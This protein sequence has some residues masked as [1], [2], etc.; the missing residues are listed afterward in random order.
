MT[1]AKTTATSALTHTIETLFDAGDV[2]ELRTFKDGA[3]FSGYYDDHDELI[4]QAAKRDELGHDVYITFNKLPKE[5]AY[6]RYNRIDR[7]KGREPTTSDKDIQRRTFIFID[8]DCER[9]SGISSTNEEKHKSREKVL[10]IRATLTKLGWPEPI[11]CDSGNGYHLLYPIDLAADQAG[12]DLVSSVLEALDFKFSDGAVKVDTTTKNAAR[13]TK[14]YGTTAKKGDNLPERPHRESKI[15]KVPDE[16][17]ATTQA[18]LEQVASMKPEE[19]RRPYQVY[20]GGTDHGRPLDLDEWTTRHNVPVKRK[21]PWQR[22]YRYI[23]EECLWNGHTDNSAYIVQFPSGGIYAGCQHDSCQTGENRWRELRKHYEPGAYEQ[24]YQAK[25]SNSANSANSANDDSDSHE[26]PEPW[27]QPAAFHSIQLPEFPRGV[28]PGWVEAQAEGVAEATQTHRDL[29]GML[30][31]GVGAAASA[32]VVDVEVWDGWKEQTNFYSAVGMRSGSRK[33]TVFQQMTAPIEEYEAQLVE[34][35]AEEIAEQRTKYKIYEERLKKAQL[36]AAKANGDDFDTLTADALT[37]AKDLLSIKV[38]AAPRLLVDDASPER[39]ATMLADQGGR[40]A[41]MSPEGGVFDMMAGR[42]SQGIPNLDVYLKGHAGDALRVD[43]V[44]RPADHVRKPALT[45]SLAVQP[46]VFQGLASRPGFRGRGLIGRVSYSIPRDTLGRRAIRPKSVSPAIE[47]SYKQKIQK[48]L[49]LAD[50]LPDGERE[51]KVLRFG[52]DAQSE[53]EVFLEWI[54]PKLAEDAEFGDMT[55]WA[56]K[57]AG[58]V[59]RIAGILHM[60]DHAGEASPWLHP[61]AGSTVRRAVKIGRYLVPHAKYAL[62]VM[63]TDPTVEDAKYILRW[64]ERKNDKRFTKRDAFE[65]TKGRFGKVAELEPGLELLT[66]H[67]YIRE[68]A[69]ADDRRGP[70]RRPSPTYEVNPLWIAEVGKTKTEH[71]SQNSQYSQNGSSAV[72][73]PSEPS[74][75]DDEVEVGL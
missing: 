45:I 53:M 59:A 5:I 60:L 68:E 39:L 49:K 22:G 33:T 43:R 37:A 74:E 13:I 12:L 11:A 3:T 46:D 71:D 73:E 42:Y 30:A 23:L 56:G 25:S 69:H 44:G 18:Q 67:G 15:L 34:D 32:K 63:G 55:D 4:K 24:Q 38:P 75:E 19:P 57:L 65:G 51:A 50:K 27:S 48:L 61:V 66:A 8:A 9:I 35:T 29:S 26:E 1:E 54:E 47:S 17:T 64:I 31:L 62:A 2:I 52:P 72:P 10:E 14:F 40:I 28:L 7:I 6:R 16:L 21:G 36:K 58:A 41:L 20:S 70:G